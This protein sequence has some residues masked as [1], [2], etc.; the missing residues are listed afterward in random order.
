MNA[1]F[2]TLLLGVNYLRPVP[3]NTLSPLSLLVFPSGLTTR[4]A[5]FTSRMTGFTLV[6]STSV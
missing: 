3:T 4:M 6:T 2:L 1:G 5:G